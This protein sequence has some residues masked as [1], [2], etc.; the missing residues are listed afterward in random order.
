M[1][2]ALFVWD[3]FP[4]DS[5]VLLA[6][7]ALVVFKV[8]T[9]NEAFQGFGTDLIMMLSSI[10]I[11]SAVLQHNGVMDYFASKF[12]LLK[13]RNY[14]LIVILLMIPVGL[15]SA[16]MNNTTLTAIMLVPVIKFAQNKNIAASKLLMPLAF[17]SLLGGTCSLI[18][19]STNVAGN[20]FLIQNGYQSIGFFE[21]FPIGIVLLVVCTLLMALFGKYFLPNRADVNSNDENQKAEHLFFA[22]FKLSA[23]T[24][25]EALN[26]E[27]YCKEQHIIIK[28][29]LN[30]QKVPL[31]KL[32]QDVIQFIF[33]EAPKEKILLFL[34][35]YNN[36]ISQI[37][38]FDE[39]EEIAELLVL[40]NSLIANNTIRNTH[41]IQLTGLEPISIFRKHFSFTDRL[42]DT[43]I[44]TGDI[45]IVKA[46]AEELL[47]VKSNSDFVI[48]NKTKAL[49][50][51]NPDLKKGFVALAIFSVAILLSVI[52]IIPISVA[53]LTALLIILSF[54][55]IPASKIYSS[56][57]WRLIIVIG[58]MSAFGVAFA[59]TGADVFLANWLSDIL[60][61]VPSLLVLFLLM[62]ITVILTQPLSNAAAALVVLP[63]AIQTAKNFNSDPRAYA[64]A[65]I[66][67]A[68]ISMVTPFEPA[69][70]LILNPG[71]YKV[72]DFVKIGGL[73]TFFCLG[74]VLL[75]INILYKL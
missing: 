64:I 73:L 33:I 43:T 21:F 38:D 63:I 70:L 27:K 23:I 72:L 9:P 56:I 48:L 61:G 67:S 59:K 31:D 19:T 47:Q 65:I 5:I 74:I 24:L 51:H 26:I 1:L 53:F 25:Q 57:N 22:S 44:N 41:F 20:N 17:A 34:K 40:P 13:T 7:I 3:K 11:I 50:N 68:S 18:G 12:S 71:R 6:L 39:N 75:M 8:I 62:L 15:L 60:Q 30:E 29:I 4:P 52:K 10:F 2:I 36:L 16:F 54:N 58:G 49:E 69:S 28:K 46:D 35:K 42:K 66:I 45:L 55:V 32:G 14:F 37:S